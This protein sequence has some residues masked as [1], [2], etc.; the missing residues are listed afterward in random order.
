MSDWQD[1][2]TPNRRDGMSRKRTIMM[3]FVLVAVVVVS[4]FVVGKIVLDSRQREAAAKELPPIAASVAIL[5]D[6]NVVFAPNGSVAQVLTDW[7]ENNDGRSRYFE[8]GGQQFIGKAIV[9]T[10]TAQARLPQLVKI[11][12]AY[13]TLKLVII[14]HTD[15]RGGE[16]ENE[17]VSRKRAE[18][19]ESYLIANGIDRKRLSVQAAGSAQPI[20]NSNTQAGRD[21]NNRIGLSMLPNG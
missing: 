3:A 8:V 14:G 21:A 17:L 10:T 1:G 15:A 12:E 7:L 20:A 16:T 4:L 5:P 18:W 6:G 2:A 9:P 13:P 19:L 11:M